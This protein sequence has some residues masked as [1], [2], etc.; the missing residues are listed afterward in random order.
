M[1]SNLSEC[2]HKPVLVLR[3]NAEGQQGSLFCK[4]E[5]SY[6]DLINFKEKSGK[7]QGLIF[8]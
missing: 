3:V 5:I 4:R 1:G 2:F 6:I 7:K 8:L